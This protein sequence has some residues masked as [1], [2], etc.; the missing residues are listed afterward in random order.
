MTFISFSYQ[1]FA[2]PLQMPSVG[3]ITRAITFSQIGTVIV[4][5]K[6][7]PWERNRQ[8]TYLLCMYNVR[9]WE[10]IVMRTL[11]TIYVYMQNGILKPVISQVVSLIRKR[12]PCKWGMCIPGRETCKDKGRAWYF[13]E[14][15]GRPVNYGAMN[16]WGNVLRAI[17]WG[18][19]HIEPC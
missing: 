18:Q 6:L 16:K 14:T 19:D 17:A 13:W 10:K 3:S 4:L 2:D 8:Y 12:K 5:I 15:L 7:H 1:K 11:P 9:H